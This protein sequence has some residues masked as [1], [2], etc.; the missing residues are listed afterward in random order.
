VADF[1]DNVVD[2]KLFSMLEG[3]LWNIEAALRGIG[4]ASF[5]GSNFGLG[6]D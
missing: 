6:L 3:P 5:I 1:V 2:D 4:A